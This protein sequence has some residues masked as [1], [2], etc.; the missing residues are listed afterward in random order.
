M[1][2]FV[3]VAAGFGFGDAVIMELLKMSG[4][5]PPLARSAAHAVVFAMDE[6]LRP[7]AMG[8][9]SA[10]RGAGVAADLV[11]ERA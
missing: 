9:A 11:L 10:L 8:A 1:A 2:A 4:K 3:G 5:L 6:E 7:Q